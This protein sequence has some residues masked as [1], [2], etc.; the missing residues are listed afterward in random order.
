MLPGAVFRC[1]TPLRATARALPHRTVL[2]QVR[3]VRNLPG[4]AA[5]AAA[6]FR[7]TSIY[8]KIADNP[9]AIAAVNKLL[10][11]MK[12]K[13]FGFDAGKP[14]SPMQMFKIGRDP[15][16]RQ[17]IITALA[18]LESAGIDVTSKET[19]DEIMGANRKP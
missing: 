17:A 15:E 1:W 5:E 7:T 16:V 11:L 2:N 4:N 14:P 12:E 10:E 19:M 3:Y 8:K 13:G 18:Q 9:E 6:Q